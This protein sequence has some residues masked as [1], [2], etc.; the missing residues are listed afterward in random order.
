[1]NRAAERPLLFSGFSLIIDEIQ[2]AP[3]LID[4]KQ[5]TD[6]YI[7]KQKVYTNI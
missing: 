3:Q 7:K 5:K 6:I 2:R 1:M 4:L